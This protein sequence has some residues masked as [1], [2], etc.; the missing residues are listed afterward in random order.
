MNRVFIILL[1][2]LTVLYSHASTKTKYPG[3][4]QY[5]Y[6]LTL[7]DKAHSPYRLDRPTRWLSA[8]SVERRRRQGLKVDSTDLPVSPLYLRTIGAQRGVSVVGT[9][10]WNNTVVIH[11]NDTAVRQRLTK[12]PFV[13]QA[14]LVWLSPDSIEKQ[15]PKWTYHKSFNAWDSIHNEHYGNSKDQIESLSGQQLHNIGLRGQGM[16]IAVLDGGFQN[17]NH[18]PVFKHTKIVGCRDLIWHNPQ[19]KASERGD[20]QVYHESDHGTRVLSA[21]AAYAP[22]VLVG[23]APEADYWLL[24]CEDQQSEQPIE[25]DYWAMA[26]ELADSAGVDI[27]NS[28]LGYNDYDSPH[29]SI[30]LS[31]LDGQSTLISRTASML[32]SKGIVLVNSAGNTGMGPWKKICVPGDADNMLTV[33]A[34]TP[35][36]INAPF[37][38]VGPSQDGRVKPDVV[39]IGSPTAL[40][41]GRGAVVRDMGTSFSTP[42]V[43]GL[44]ACLWQ[45]MPHKSA[46]EIINLIRS[47]SD[48]HL[49]PNNIYGYGMPNFWQAFMIGNLK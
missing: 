47:T 14:E 37:S 3:G 40:I 22:E 8:K 23:T 11:T 41:S 4:Q 10:R 39:A 27:I 18:I 25:E 42:V 49:T 9:S 24:R 28:S 30:R 5:M 16:T 15:Q 46:I 6:R 32:A 44:V 35:Q 21:M 20:E 12:L 29:Q 38:A 48:N 19:M 31:Q 33:G 34:V 17:V 43:C 26:A 45:S 2:L 13:K 1:T 36:G 7:T